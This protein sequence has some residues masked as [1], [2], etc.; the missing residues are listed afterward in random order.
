VSKKSKKLGRLDLSIRN[1]ARA[2][3]RKAS[4]IRRAM[5]SGPSKVLARDLRRSEVVARL[6]G[7]S[8]ATI[9]RAVSQGPSKKLARD[10]RVLA[11]SFPKK[12]PPKKLPP[13]KLPSKKLPPKKLPPKKL[14][15]KKLPSKKL[16]PKKLPPKKLPPKKLPPKKLPPKKL[17]PKKL[18]PKKLPPKKLPPKKLPSKKLPPKK[19]PPKK[20]PPK[21]L[22]PKK[23]LPKKRKPKKPVKHRYPT[24]MRQAA[25]A[26]AMILAKLDRLGNTLA[27][28]EPDVGTTIK[29]FINS[30]ATVDGELR[31]RDLPE[32]WRTLEGMPAVVAT[33][34]EAVRAM[35]A[36]PSFSPVGG[37]FWISCGLRFGPKNEQE[38]E[39]M[40]K[41][42]KRFRGLLQVGAYPTTAQALPAILNNVLAIRYLIER[43][44]VKRDLPPAQLLVRIVWTPTTVKPG[45]FAGEEGD[46]P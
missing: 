3:G 31:M 9:K 6:T 11:K 41:F 10:L 19:L 36:F 27:A 14:P 40:A 34:S 17:P 22:P 32:E 28:I 43:V 45:R 4:T 2:T 35:G 15:P 13:K 42:Y 21:K 44:W 30:D 37:A 20:L 16:P 29:S 39:D 8:S 38:I 25:S 1:L 7:R 26:E 24:F 23:L 33:L 18:P 5:S 46:K 12:L